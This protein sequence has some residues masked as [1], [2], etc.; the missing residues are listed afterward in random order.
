L[1]GLEFNKLSLGFV[2]TKTKV[3]P[4]DK[5]DHLADAFEENNRHS[6]PVSNSPMKELQSQIEEV[7][8]TKLGPADATIKG[9]KESNDQFALDSDEERALDES[10]FLTY[11]RLKISEE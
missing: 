9:D 2:V 10:L 4:F 3:S 7:S 5:L 1:E 11:E 8:N 6:S